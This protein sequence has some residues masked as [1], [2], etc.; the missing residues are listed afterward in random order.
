MLGRLCVHRQQHFMS[1][2]HVQPDRGQV[3][4]GSVRY[5]TSG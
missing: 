4:L 5:L 2:N 1:F 3:T